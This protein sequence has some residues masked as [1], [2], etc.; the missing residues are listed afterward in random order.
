MNTSN[1]P[2]SPF[3]E[4]PPLPPKV[5]VETVDTLKVCIEAR[6]SL[7]E[8]K[9][10]AD[11]LPNPTLLINLIPILEAK[12]SS[13]IENIVT[14]TDRLF[15]Y[16]DSEEHADPHTKEALR[17]RTALRQGFEALQTKPLCTNSAV[18]ICSI[19]KSKP[20]HIRNQPGTAL[21]NQ[22]TGQIIYTPP[23]GE[24][25]LSRLMS[26]WENYIHERDGV[27]P[28]IKM[29]ISHYQ[30]EA[31]HP[32]L[33]GNGRTGRIVNVLYLIEAGLLTLPILY[34]SRYIIQN[35]NDYYRLLREVTWQNNWQDWILFILR[36]VH[37]TSQW[38]RHKISAIHGLIQHT[39]DFVKTNLPK[40][41]SHELV[42]TLFQQPYCRI[43]NLVESGIAKRQT[44]SVYL[45][46]LSGIGVLKETSS[47]KEK[48]FIHPKLIQ[49]MSEDSNTISPYHS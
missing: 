46:Q 23:Q 30:F 18:D 11:F 48:L 16:A 40:I 5:E 37:D 35:K 15:Q 8:L 49:L 2:S 44:A 45:K 42:H 4:L 28:L 39:A 9:Q 38:T 32:F 27:D 25:I 1:D 12:D 41:Y 47:G 13:A 24:A 21:A 34:L 17:Y 19:L 43:N 33:D 7:A 14:T 6:S 31:I 29:A 26:N 3:N 10:A 36:G 22:Y 20:M